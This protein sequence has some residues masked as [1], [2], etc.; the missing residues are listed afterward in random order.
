MLSII[1]KYI[2]LFYNI[3]E[4]EGGMFM[5]YDINDNTLLNTF[6]IGTIFL[7]PILS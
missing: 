6:C 3:F 2:I 5:N 4:F 7:L 1:D